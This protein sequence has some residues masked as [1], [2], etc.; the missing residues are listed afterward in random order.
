MIPE[1][2]VIALSGG[3]GMPFAVDMLE[4]L[5]ATEVETHLVITNGAKQVI[6]SE[7]DA[8][9]RDLEALADVVHK[10]QDLGAAIASG[11]YRV[12][13]M[14]VV[15]CSAGTLAKVAHGMTDNLVSRAAHVM[16]KERRPLV[17]V[18][19][20]APYGRPLLVNMLAAYDA[21]AT[22]MPASPGFYHRPATVHDLV[23]GLTAR[24]LDH[25]GIEHDHAPRWKDA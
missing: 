4:A 1:R 15:P 23:R 22:I 9:V 14:V 20:E 12:R 18:V 11:S 24:V 21:G 3:S 19:R 5:R 7:I 16:L 2:I 13:G 6:P 10:D 8:S 17:L 25:L